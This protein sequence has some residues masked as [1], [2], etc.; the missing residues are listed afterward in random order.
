MLAA[1]AVLSVT[2]FLTV[3]DGQLVSV[4]LATIERALSLAPVNAQWVITGYAIPLAGTLLLAG[5]LGDQM[6]HRR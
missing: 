6:G 4:A 2:S 5:R 1:A 3:F